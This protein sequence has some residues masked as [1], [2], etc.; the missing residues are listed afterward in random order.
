VT[1]PNFSSLRCFARTSPS[2]RL[3][4]D[5]VATG[6]FIYNRD[7]NGC[8]HQRQLAGGAVGLHRRRHP[9]RWTGPAV[10]PNVVRPERNQQR[11]GTRSPRTSCWQSGHRR[12]WLF[13]ASVMKP[14]GRACSSRA[15]TAT[16][17]QNTWTRAVSRRL[18]EC[19]SDRVGFNKPSLAFSS[20]P[21]HRFFISHRTRS[22]I[23]VGA[24][25]VAA[26]FN[27]S[28]NGNSSYI[29]GATQRRYRTKT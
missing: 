16:R 23:R 13:S 17:D 7:V 21:R 11:A 25:T 24:T 4:W 18:V 28:Q 5:L 8:L 26:Y 3:P 6:E 15:P 9:P 12:S 27:V 20:L 29:S 10:P 19:Q 22:S 2:K 1:D 14:C